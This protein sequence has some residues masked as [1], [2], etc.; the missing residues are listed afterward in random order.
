MHKTAALINMLFGGQTRASS[1][2]YACGCSLAPP[3]KYDEMIGRQR[4]CVDSAEM[5]ERIEIPFGGFT[6]LSERFNVLN[7]SR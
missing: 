5:A 6:R 1:K 3:G 4:K 2:H 7:S